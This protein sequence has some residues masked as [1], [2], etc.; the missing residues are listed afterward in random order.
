MDPPGNARMRRRGRAW[1]FGLSGP[2][3]AVVLSDRVV[4]D[5]L[6]DSRLARKSLRHAGQKRQGSTLPV[7]DLSTRA[8]A[9]HSW[10]W[11]VA[12]FLGVYWDLLKCLYSP[13]AFLDRHFK[14]HQFSGYLQRREGIC[15]KAA[16]G[17][18]LPTLG[19]GLILLWLL[20]LAHLRDG[21][22]E[23][24]GG[25]HD[26]VQTHPGAA[27]KDRVVFGVFLPLAERFE[28]SVASLELGEA[29]SPLAHQVVVGLDVGPS[30]QARKAPIELL[31]R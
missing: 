22:N 31:A 24:M 10:H 20:F 27:A 23:M 30:V 13:E 25:G 5:R 8:M 28:D 1:L 18:R 15:Q 9:P 26:G 4:G 2:S 7:M 3:S 16:E 19:Y 14:D 6:A 29:D 17:K 11:T 12:D 21:S